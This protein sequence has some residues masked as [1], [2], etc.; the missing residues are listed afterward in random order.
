MHR[1]CSNRL[2]VLGPQAELQRFLGSKWER[3]LHPRHGEWMENSPGRFV[4]LFDTD[5]P[6]LE[7]LRRL[8]GRWPNLVFLLDYE[9]DSER[10]RGLAKAEA[11]RLE[12]WST[13]Y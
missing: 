13:T 3:R 5:E 2:T 10:M 1:W 8:S 6:C 7:G 9:I 12:H 11:G 4:C